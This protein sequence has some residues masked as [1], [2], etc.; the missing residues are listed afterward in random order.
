VITLMLAA[1]VLA[2]LAYVLWPLARRGGRPGEPRPSALEDLE[3]PPREREGGER[4]EDA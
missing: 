4:R 1:I 2:T 3:P